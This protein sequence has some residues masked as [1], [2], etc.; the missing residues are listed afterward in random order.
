MLRVQKTR[1]G[2]WLWTGALNKK[3]YGI[4]SFQGKSWLV[5]HLVF[6]VLVEPVP[7]GKEVDHICHSSGD[8]C[9]GIK[10]PHR[11]CIN[12][13]HLRAISHAENVRL[14]RRL[15]KTHCPQGHSYSLWG[16]DH[17]GSRVCILCT[18]E[19]ARRRYR[20]ANPVDRSNAAKTHCS[21]GHLY[22]QRRGGENGQRICFECR[23]E[24]DR[25]RRPP[26]G[27]VY[28]TKPK[29]PCAIQGCGKDAT[30]RGWCDTHYR[31]WL[32]RR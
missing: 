4:L 24:R 27:R 22:E 9:L 15:H 31:Q 12:P 14:M 17:N 26:K 8:C 32:R 3:G 7:V 20:I 18:R 25:R 19:Q 23:R 13:A 29:L 16:R 6:T 2:C 10:C 5:H 30:R 21:K 1:D 11:R 28:T